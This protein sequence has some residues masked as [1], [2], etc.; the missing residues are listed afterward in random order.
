LLENCAPPRRTG[1]PSRLKNLSPLYLPLRISFEPIPRLAAADVYAS[2]SGPYGMT[3]IS[4]AFSISVMAS[5][6]T[7]A[8]VIIF[9][10]AM[11]GA[12]CEEQLRSLLI[13]SG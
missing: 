12:L 10:A 11:V 1:R 13:E 4:S 9:E 5:M 7:D 6:L 8:V 3:A 2:L